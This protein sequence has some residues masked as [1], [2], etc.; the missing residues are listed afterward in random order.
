M[1]TVETNEAPVMRK[2]RAM[3]FIKTSS[4]EKDS[5]GR[6]VEPVEG[7]DSGDEFMAEEGWAKT[8]VE[9]GQAVYEE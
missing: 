4:N 1:E 3:V 5:D 7:H 6:S 8:L 2:V 9:S